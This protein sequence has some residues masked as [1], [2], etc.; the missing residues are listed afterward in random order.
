MN[1][2]FTPFLFIVCLFMTACSNDEPDVPGL[3]TGSSIEFSDNDYT[4]VFGRATYIPFTGGGD[5][6]KLEASNP[7]VLGKFGIDIETHRLLINPAKTG[8]STLKINDVNNGKTVTLNFTVEDFYL[9]FR[10]SEIEGDN[11]NP[12]LSIGNEIRFIRDNEN[13]RQMKV[14]W[15]DKLTYEVNCIADGYFDIE[16]SETNI[17]TLN[18][19]LHSQRIEELETFT[20]TMSGD[21]E[22]LA[23]FEKYFEYNWL[24]NVASKSQPPKDI[25]MILT[26]PLSDAK[27]ICSL[28]PF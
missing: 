12:S 15:H 6:Y 8:V 10:V 28:Q 11:R 23:L 3:E 2:L 25:K 1:K 4:L 18:M 17:Y 16:Q 7:E 9:S 21:W 24:D 27:I 14:M 13:T 20:Y 26:D 22:Y 5:V 19:A